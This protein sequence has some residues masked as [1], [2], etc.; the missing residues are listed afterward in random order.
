MLLAVCGP[1]TV[2]AYYYLSWEPT[3]EVYAVALTF[4]GQLCV[5]YLVNI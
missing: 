4:R 5:P 1:Q 3:K 2:E